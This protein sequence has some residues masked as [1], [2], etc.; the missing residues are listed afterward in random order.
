M[1]IKYSNFEVSCSIELPV[2]TDNYWK[3]DITVYWGNND[4]F[5]IP[6]TELCFYWTE[7]ILSGNEE[8]AINAIQGLLNNLKYKIEKMEFFVKSCQK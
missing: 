4:L 3:N 1:R 7:D 8:K 2:T 6:S 5:I